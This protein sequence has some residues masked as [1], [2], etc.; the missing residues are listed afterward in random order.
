MKNLFSKTVLLSSFL[1]FFTGVLFFVGCG[2]EEDV[3]LDEAILDSSELEEYIIAG[4]DLQRSLAIFFDGL[5][6]IDFST[7][8]VSYDV[9]GKKII[10][11]PAAFVESNRIEEKIQTFNKKKENAQKKYP[12]ILSFSLK[13]RKDY[14]NHSIQSSVNVKNKLMELGYQRSGSLLKN[15]PNQG[16]YDWSGGE[17]D[18]LSAM[19]AFLYSHLNSSDYVEVAIY[20][21]TDGTYA[22]YIHEKNTSQSAEVVYAMKNGVAYFPS[23]LGG[24]ANSQI[25]WVAHTHNTGPEPTPGREQ[26]VPGVPNKIYYNGSFY[27]FENCD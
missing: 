27:C 18:G 17:E 6:K 21:Y 16:Y 5:T 8:D 25:L 24:N 9:E 14:I 7:L 22:T 13:T 3:P 11:L 4:A 23:Q 26:S 2:R 19:E 20:A 10:H 1:I 15:S 12:Q